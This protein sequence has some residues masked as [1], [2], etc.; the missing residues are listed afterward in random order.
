MH[1]QNDCDNMSE[2]L[3]KP[4]KNVGRYDDAIRLCENHDLGL[5]VSEPTIVSMLVRAG[6]QAVGFGKWHLGYEKKFWPL[7]HGFEYYLG[8]LGGGVDYFYHTEWDGTPVLFENDQF[9]QREGY[10]TDIITDGAL[11]FLRDYDGQKPFFLY[12]PYT[13]PH[14]PIQ[15]PDKKPPVPRRKENWNEGSRATYAKMNERLDQGIGKILRALEAKGLV[16]DTLV[17]F[18]SDNG[19]TRTAR[20]APF[21]GYKGGCFEGGIRVPCIV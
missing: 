11:K 16:D 10:M 4:P 13:C 20:I 14:T 17:I 5:P 3:Q 15:D 8:P 2:Y 19:G 1:V 18:C 6:Y 12:L 21:S 7:R 9:I